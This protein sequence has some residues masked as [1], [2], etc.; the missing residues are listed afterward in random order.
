MAGRVSPAITPTRVTVSQKEPENTVMVRNSATWS[1][2]TEQIV[3][4][5]CMYTL[6][7][8]KLKFNLPIFPGAPGSLT[9]T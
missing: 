7:Q 4:I 2:V 3:L 1:K 6:L 5:K 8:K 9:F